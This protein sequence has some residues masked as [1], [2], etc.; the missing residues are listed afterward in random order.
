[1]RLLWREDGL[2]FA[3]SRGRRNTVCCD[4]D[5]VRKDEEKSE[6]SGK[7]KMRTEGERAKMR[8][9]EKA[10]ELAQLASY[11]VPSFPT[12]SGWFVDEPTTVAGT[13][14]GGKY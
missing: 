6:G 10:S 7:D 12:A 2:A 11:G 9:H 3:P 8:A 1:M 13:E 14:T 4:R 5:E